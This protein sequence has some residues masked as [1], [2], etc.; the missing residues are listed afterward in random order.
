MKRLMQWFVLGLLMYTVLPAMAQ[1]PSS[2][3]EKIPF[4]TPLATYGDIKIGLGEFFHFQER[5]L[6]DLEKYEGEDR[7][8]LID[9]ALQT[10]IFQTAIYNI[11]IEQGYGSTYEYLSR[12]EDMKNRMLAAFYTY[13]QFTR[14]YEDDEAALREMYEAEKEKYFQPAKFTFRHIFV[15]T[16]DLPED[17]QQKAAERVKAAYELIQN[18][19]D[20]LDVAKEYSDSERKGAVVG[21]FNLRSYNE[22]RAINPVLE[23]EL[24][25]LK[26]G[27]MSGIVQT[28]YGFEILKLESYSDDLYRPFE[29]LKLTLSN[30][31]KG[32]MREDWK[33]SLVEEHWDDAVSQFE[34]SL[35]FDP[36]AE[37]TAD[38][39]V[40]YNDHINLARY[41][42]LVPQK[43]RREADESEEDYNA[44]LV[45]Q[46]KY[47]VIFNYIA[48]K[49]AWDI[50]FTDIPRYR[51]LTKVQEYQTVYSVWWNKMMQDYVEAN[52]LSEEDKRE[53]YEQ[54]KQYFMGPSKSLVKEMSFK[55]PEHNE[56][57]MY[58]KFKAEE[59]AKEKAMQAIERLKNGEEFSTVAKDLSESP[60]AE[61]GGEIGEITFQ[62][63]ALPKMVS[64]EAMKLTE[65]DF[66]KEPVKDGETYYVLYCYGKPERESLAFDD[67][68][69]QERI[70]RAI[71]NLKQT[72][73]YKEKME[74]IV[75]ADEINMLYPDVYTLSP[76]M[77]ESTS[78]YLP[79]MLDEEDASEE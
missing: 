26:P 42:Q 13:H 75:K 79:G 68:A 14:V 67:P 76:A 72:K 43:L 66:T 74:E 70:N 11:A 4:N 18:G 78:L 1:E 63:D 40:V 53:Y 77:I 6:R 32:E 55:V 28:K 47:D 7:K 44:R 35:I 45:D 54:N 9:N 24:M 37:M 58:E 17:E 64:R 8:Q 65:G 5:M 41:Q 62:T 59:A 19:S 60:T 38:V 51:L 49:L 23:E 21:P 69:S 29:Q 39:A 27:E 31:L 52:P 71:P 25:K 61:Q 57:V 46:L 2:G 15:R 20:F 50:N 22:E 73:F 48:A 10:L 3:K 36:N 16:V 12:T 34:P 33:R 56:D 30:R